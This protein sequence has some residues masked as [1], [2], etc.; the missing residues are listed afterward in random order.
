M[1]VLSKAE[2]F[3][4]STGSRI[5]TLRIGEGVVY[6]RGMTFGE[7]RRW[8]AIAETDP[9]RSMLILALS[10]ICSA[11]GGRM[12]G[13]DEKA[14]EELARSICFADVDR[15]G[16]LVLRLSGLDPEPGD[17]SPRDATA[18]DGEK[19]FARSGASAAGSP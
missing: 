4:E 14:E 16:K 2:L 18:E 19:N 13:D 3:A 15:I 10:G 9:K 7:T 11:E 12:F 17:G 8:M 5:E 1:K 6:V